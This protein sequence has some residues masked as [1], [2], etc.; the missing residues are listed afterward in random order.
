MERDVSQDA[1]AAQEVVSRSGQMGVPVTIADGEVIVGFDRARL[2]TL[3]DRY[4]Q[5]AGGR[6]RLGV[7]ARDAAGGGAEIGRVNTGEPAERAGLRP[8]D[9]V[10]AINGSPVHGVDG[11]TALLN[12][13]AEGVPY[14]I[15]FRRGSQRERVTVR[16]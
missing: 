9:V 6:S 1:A 13:L 8:G 5:P 3:A 12:G 11:L 7:A 4:A 16:W 14:E 15:T 2:T 10:E